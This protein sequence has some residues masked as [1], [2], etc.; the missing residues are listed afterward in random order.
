[1]LMRA[2][3]VMD[4]DDLKPLEL[5][6]E[7]ADVK[8]LLTEDFE[9]SFLIPSFE[10]RATTNYQAAPSAY[11]GHGNK[12]AYVVQEGRTN[13]IFAVFHIALAAQEYRSHFLSLWNN[14]PQLRLQTPRAKIVVGA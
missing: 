12:Y 5:L 11:F 1:M 4:C 7:V 13:F 2:L 10:Y 3:G 6:G 9:P 14:A 8:C